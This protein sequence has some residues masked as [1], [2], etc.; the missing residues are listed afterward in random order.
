[1][2]ITHLDRCVEPLGAVARAF[3]RPFINGREKRVRGT[4]RSLLSDRCE[5]GEA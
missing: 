3:E 5:A 2:A 1:V 4:Q